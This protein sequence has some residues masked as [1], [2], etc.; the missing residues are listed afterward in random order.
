MIRLL[1]AAALALSGT[2]AA[3][4]LDPFYAKRADVAGIPVLGSARAPDQALRRAEAIV[5][6]MLRHRPDIRRELLR[7]GVRVAVLAP[8]EGIMDLPEHRGWRKPEPDDPR[9]TQC[10]REEY[11]ARIAP[12]SHRDYW[13]QRARGI[14]GTLTA[15]GAE[16]LLARPGSVYFGENI[17]VHEFAHPILSAIE[18]VDPPLHGR[19]RA[20]YE[21]A[22]AAG[23]WSGDYA[24]VT[25]QEYW[26]EGT[27]FWFNSNMISRLDDGTIL[28]ADD[29]RNYDPALHSA[30]GEVYGRSHRI[31]ADP[32]YM[33]IARLDVPPGRKS[34]DC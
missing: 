7:M 30:L 23:K 21:S 32:F 9:L 4:P 3:T 22:L 18:R 24:A 14:G 19:I 20:A 28:S 13:N 2:A 16:N 1:A 8:E 33:H 5:A 6:S 17:L 31:A 10:E 29:L 34:A 26:A 15:V 11:Q 25:L 12:L 27:Q